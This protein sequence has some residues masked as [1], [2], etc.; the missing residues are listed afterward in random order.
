M[1]CVSATFGDD[2]PS[3]ERGIALTFAPARPLLDPDN[4]LARLYYGRN[5]AGD[6]PT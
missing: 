5:E 3:R 1:L 6:P 4:P 2:D